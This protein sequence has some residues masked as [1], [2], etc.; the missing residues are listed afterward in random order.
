[1]KKCTKCNKNKASS[2]RWCVQCNWAARKAGGVNSKDFW[3]VRERWQPQRRGCR[4]GELTE[5][6]D[7]LEIKAYEEFG[8]KGCICKRCQVQRLRCR[9]YNISREELEALNTGVCGICGTTESGY[10]D[11]HI[12]HDHET[13]EIRGLLCNTC[14]L[15]LG[16]FK[17]NPALLEAAVQYLKEAQDGSNDKTS[18][19]KPD[20]T[21][22]RGSDRKRS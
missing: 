21:G 11:F 4:P 14:N 19:N 6:V 13:G 17:D 2:N 3:E 12:D 18:S 22:R 10:Y 16:H 15:G 7:C 9:T 1:M 20:A 5:C 8:K